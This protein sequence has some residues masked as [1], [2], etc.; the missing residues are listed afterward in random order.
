[1]TNE[2]VGIAPLTWVLDGTD[3]TYVNKSVQVP[4]S[5]G[6]RPG[7]DKEFLMRLS[8]GVWDVRLE[9]YRPEVYGTPNPAM[10]FALWVSGFTSAATYN[11]E[12]LKSY[13]V[14][15]VQNEEFTPQTVQVVAPAGGADIAVWWNPKSADEKG[16]LTYVTVTATPRPLATT[17]WLHTI[18]LE[19]T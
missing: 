18:D 3:I 9:L 4:I 1:M 7:V 2:L 5:V 15:S 10:Y 11:N 8:E 14:W 13:R 17:N 19:L 6:K 12:P 16:K